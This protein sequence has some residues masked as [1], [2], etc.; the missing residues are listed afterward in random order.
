MASPE[1]LDLHGLGGR[2]LP[3][4]STDDLAEH[5]YIESL[6]KQSAYEEYRTEVIEAIVTK[7]I[8][9]QADAERFMSRLEA[10][11]TF[12]QLN[13]FLAEVPMSLSL[14][15]RENVN[16]FVRKNLDILGPDYPMDGEALYT[17]IEL[18]IDEREIFK[19]VGSGGEG[20]V[21]KSSRVPSP[22]EEADEGLAPSP[23]QLELSSRHTHFVAI[24]FLIQGNYDRVHPEVVTSILRPPGV[25]PISCVRQLRSPES[26]QPQL[27][28]VMEMG[29]TSALNAIDSEHSLKGR[30]TI[31]LKIAYQVS[32]LHESGRVH[33]DLKFQNAIM[34]KDGR[35]KLIDASF[36]QRVGDRAPKRPM[37]LIYSSPPE[38]VAVEANGGSD[39]E[40]ETFF[41][42]WSLG[43]MQYEAFM[44]KLPDLGSGFAFVYAIMMGKYSEIMFPEQ[45]V[46]ELKAEIDS[47]VRELVA[48]SEQENL[49]KAIDLMLSA[50]TYAKLYG[51][52]E[53]EKREFIAILQKPHDQL[54][55]GDVKRAVD[56]LN[57]MPGS[58]VGDFSDYLYHIKGSFN[59]ISFQMKITA[60]PEIVEVNKR[61]LSSV[62]SD[63]G[64]INQY[65]KDLSEVVAQLR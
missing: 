54:T 30:L 22:R 58:F 5:L 9:E 15:A 29:K 36:S 60:F 34:M 50:E 62:P 47:Q 55:L 56:F 23:A 2:F 64:D 4:E 39:M 6:E 45:T 16:S 49:S 21:L 19:R 63:R 25:L 33:M 17:F 28:L 31:L 32:Q 27:G 59:I 20:V 65:I 3:L 24:K 51:N 40:V 13:Q 1:F 8:V 61:L 52:Y 12:D 35:A 37:T 41:D 18:L 46:E 43:I 48:E 44:G 57:N 10:V 42:M 7:R 11:K 14:I 26:G 53:V 38:S